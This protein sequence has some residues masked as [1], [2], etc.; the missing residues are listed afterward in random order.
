[1][2]PLMTFLNKFSVNIED[3]GEVH[4]YDKQYFKGEK[5]IVKDDNLLGAGL[6]LGESKDKEFKPSPAMMELIS[7]NCDKKI[8]VDEKA[9]W[10]FLCGRDLF[11]KSIIRSNVDSG[12]VLIQNEHDENL[13]Y[14]KIISKVDTKTSKVVVKNILD[15]GYYL[16]RE[17]K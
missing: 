13:G 3:I 2:E 7:K 10:L 9:E 4:K 6:F 5:A 8:F 16:R 11:G 17:R 14:G 1:M 12:L 15:R